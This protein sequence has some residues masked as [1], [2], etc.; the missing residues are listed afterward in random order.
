MEA[1]HNREPGTVIAALLT[2]IH[3][4]FRCNSHNPTQSGCFDFAVFAL[5]TAGHKNKALF[6]L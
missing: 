3:S 2:G 1:W 6:I 4:G 5:H